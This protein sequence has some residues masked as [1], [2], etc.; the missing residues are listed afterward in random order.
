MSL[1]LTTGLTKKV[2]LANFGSIGASC[3][4]ELEID[5]ASLDDLEVFHRRA[6]HAFVACRQAVHDELSRYADR[7]APVPAGNGQANGSHQ[8]NGQQRSG[9]RKATASQVRAIHAIINRQ[10]LDLSQTLHGHCGVEFAEDLTIAQAS[11]LIDE[12]K[13]QANGAAERR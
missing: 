10:G 7:Q 8:G 1:R 9:D 12:L 6:L 13:A 4:I 3:S 5:A 2:G 11:Q